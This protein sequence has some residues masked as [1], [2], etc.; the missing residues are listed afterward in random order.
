M[1]LNALQCDATGDE[2]MRMGK[3]YCVSDHVP[4]L[5]TYVKYSSFSSIAFQAQYYVLRSYKF[6]ANCK[7]Q[8]AIATEQIARGVA[9]YDRTRKCLP[10]FLLYA[11][12]EDILCDC[13]KSEGVVH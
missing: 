9:R 13:K 1:L 10:D 4:S 11:I 7:L 8:I 3:I 2:D 5:Y 12:F 6:I